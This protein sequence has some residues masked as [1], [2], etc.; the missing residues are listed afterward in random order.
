MAW[1]DRLS[2]VINSTRYTRRAWTVRKH[3]FGVLQVPSGALI[4]S[5][6]RRELRGM[7]LSLV[8]QLANF[9][10]G[11]TC[12][13]SRLS[14]GCL[15]FARIH[16]PTS[17]G[18]KPSRDFPRGPRDCRAKRRGAARS[19]REAR[20]GEAEASAPFLTRQPSLCHHSWK[21]RAP[22]KPALAQS[23]QCGQ[24]GRRSCP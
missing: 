21:R 10:R 8:D 9:L 7:L 15:G 17:R 24:Q 18:I 6:Q 20:T 4:I 5:L 11:R 1:K 23:R 13:S 22:S 19:P 16:P 3:R 12:G 2:A 14:Q